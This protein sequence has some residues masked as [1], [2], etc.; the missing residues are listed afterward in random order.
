[1]LKGKAAFVGIG[2]TSV[3]KV[4]EMTTYDLYLE[5]SAKAIEDAEICQTDINGLVPLPHR[6][7]MVAFHAKLAEHMGLRLNYIGGA[8]VGGASC[9]AA[10]IHAAY[11]ILA[12][13]TD[14]V[15][16]NAGAK[17]RT[18]AAGL[19]DAGRE[20]QVRWLASE[21]GHP[22]Y[23]IPFGILIPAG[24]ALMARRH[25]YEFGT[26]SEQLA[27][28]AV[29]TRANALMNPGAQMYSKGPITVDDVLNSP[30]IADPL[31]I[32]DIS[33]VSDGGA[34]FI[35]ASEE[36]AKDITDKPIYILG[37]GEGYTHDYTIQDPDLTA[38]V[39]A[40]MSGQAA[41]RMAG[42]TP[43][44]IDIALIY[45][46][47]T[48]LVIELLEDLGFCKKGEGGPFAESHNLTWNGTFPMNT[49]GGLLS[50]AHPGMPG[51]MFHVTEAVRQ[52]RG[53]AGARQVK[54]A[55]IALVH[56]CGGVAA[57][58]S[59]LILGNVIP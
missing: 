28:V 9:G 24:F 47:T 55:K 30:I 48:I 40:A 16:C 22:S 10:A 34:A 26:N 45:D 7:T 19:S 8:D 58:H 29:D 51:G 46:A 32:L 12:G 25:M 3:G 49:H 33:L 37:V 15:L 27:R 39:G 18:G 52:L 2:E 6:P 23:E 56:T 53:E 36:R 57:T 42:I 1:M 14:L 4:P 43:R 31:H 38:R 44:D 50:F 54:D 17:G 21:A 20:A 13:N 59:T 11:A 5:A 35:V 41:F